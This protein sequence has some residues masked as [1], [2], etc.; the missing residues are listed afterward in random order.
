MFS[1]MQSKVDVANLN[2]CCKMNSRHEVA[3]VNL[4]VSSVLFNY[5]NIFCNFLAF[6]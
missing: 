4:F 6:S 3:L 1:R 2:V 5:L